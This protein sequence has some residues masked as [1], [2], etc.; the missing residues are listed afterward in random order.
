MSYEVFLVYAI[1]YQN[2][3][4]ITQRKLQLVNQ[5]IKIKKIEKEN[6]LYSEKKRGRYIKK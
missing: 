6:S 2:S 1:M 4:R 5:I 3:F